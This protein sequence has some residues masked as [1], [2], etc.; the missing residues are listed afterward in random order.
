MSAFRIATVGCGGM[1]TTGHGPAY[2]RYAATRAGT[3]LVACCDLD[4]ERAETFRARF[5]FAR[6]Y[7]DLD[8][9]LDRERPGAVALVAPVDRTCDLACRIL[10]RGIPLL[11]EKP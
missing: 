11:T 9:M 3:V 7:T 2:A 8:V 6:A 10:E 4:P 5:G 1:A